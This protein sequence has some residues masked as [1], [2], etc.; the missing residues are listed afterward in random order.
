MYTRAITRRPG[1]DF[2]SGITTQR[3]GP[4]DHAAMLRQHA[5]YVA[6]LSDLGLEV[7]VL[8]PLPGHPDAYFVEDAA[9]VTPSLAVI[10]RPG[11][12]ARR[13]EVPT[14]EAALAR[15]RRIARI[16][17]PGTLDGGD[18]L[19]AGGRAFI[20]L[21]GRTNEDGA[22]QLGRLLERDGLAWEAVPVEAGLHLKSGVNWLGED[23]LLV[24]GAFAEAPAFRG[25]RTVVVAPGEEYA[26]NTLWIN[27]RLLTPAGF[28]G[29]ARKLAA[30]G[31][32][33][34]ELEVGEA[35]KMDGGLTCMSLRF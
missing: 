15:H 35:R 2:G 3:L 34:V 4:P 5:A 10:T 8:P 12:E 22:A 9:V 23:R 24:T 28:P 31:L 14:V 20:G 11:A 26:A 27:G 19:I 33:V 17:P 16:E 7:E 6:A 29:T 21:S 18:V 30:L 1:A 32:G 25:W 13:G